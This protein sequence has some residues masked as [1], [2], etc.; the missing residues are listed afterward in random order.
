MYESLEQIR[1]L[2]AAA[3][4]LEPAVPMGR[5][6]PTSRVLLVVSDEFEHQ[7]IERYL[8]R[9]GFKTIAPDPSNDLHSSPLDVV[10]VRVG[11]DECLSDLLIGQF[12]RL[13]GD[14]PVIALADDPAVGV[15][16][17]RGG[18][19]MVMLVP[20]DLELL[21]CSIDAAANRRPTSRRRLEDDLYE[22]LDR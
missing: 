19:D 16:A 15:R 3:E 13:R 1:E 5:L 22:A 20:V 11:S 4:L 10:L 14:V 7:M 8:C 9:K 18:A 12:R 21:A 17:Y 2:S 6:I